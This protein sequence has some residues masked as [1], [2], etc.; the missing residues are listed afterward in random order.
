MMGSVDALADALYNAANPADNETVVGAANAIAGG[1]Q[2]VKEGA[3]GLCAGAAQLNAGAAEL[4]GG[5]DALQTGLAQLSGAS[6]TVKD[7]IGQFQTGAAQLATGGNTLQE[8]MDTYARDA[9][10]KLTDKLDAATLDALTETLDAVQQRAQSYHSYT[11]CGE[12]MQCSVKFVMKTQ[13]A[14]DASATPT[15]TAAAE[16]P[17]P[18]TQDAF[19][20]RV[21]NLF[22]K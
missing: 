1:A 16:A 9:I 22:V 8:G 17:A 4:S 6:K 14:A 3:D 15:Q 5:A 20:T 18:K 11:G 7:A 19:W 10:G 12:E 2:T 21:K 13:G